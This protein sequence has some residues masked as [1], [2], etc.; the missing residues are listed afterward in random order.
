VSRQWNGDGQF[1]FLFSLMGCDL[2]EMGDGEGGQR[3]VYVVRTISEAASG[4]LE[5][6]FVALD[7][8]GMVKDL[9]KEGQWIRIKSLDDLRRRGCVKVSLDVLGRL[10]QAGD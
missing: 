5:L 1:E 6:A 2:V 3:R 7:R 4:Q 9:R 10:R 8:A